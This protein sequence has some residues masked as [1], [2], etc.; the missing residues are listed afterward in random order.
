MRKQT[1]LEMSL[2][3]L[4]SPL[5]A[6]AGGLLGAT[7]WGWQGSLA[8]F[9]SPSGARWPLPRARRPTTSRTRTLRCSS[10]LPARSLE[11]R[12]CRQKRYDA[13]SGEISMRGSWLP[14][15]STTRSWLR[16][17]CSRRRTARSR[18]TA[19]GPCRCLMFGP[20]PPRTTGNAGV[21]LQGTSS[22]WTQRPSGG[23]LRRSLRASSPR[24]S[25]RQYES[26]Q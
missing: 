6:D 16:R 18:S 14:K 3:C 9:C 17:R 1:L 26:G 25:W 10:K 12:S 19:R 8:T 13:R 15:P 5:A 21:A 2:R 20:G 24:R 22:N 7:P 23:Q 4:G 11:S